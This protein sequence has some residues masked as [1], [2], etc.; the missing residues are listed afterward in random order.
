MISWTVYK[1][2]RLVSNIFSVLSFCSVVTCSSHWV[3]NISL[4]CITGI[5]AELSVY[6]SVKYED[7]QF[8]LMLV[9]FQINANVDY[10]SCH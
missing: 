2:P 7:S 5:M 10:P 3:K 4:V 9:S 1:G 8:M 6:T